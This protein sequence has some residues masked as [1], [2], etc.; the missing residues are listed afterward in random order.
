[1]LTIPHK[2][3]FKSGYVAI[4]GRPNVGKSTLLN[5]LLNLRLSSVTR[6]PQTTRHQIRGILN[7]TDHQIVFLDTPGI[8]APRY[9][10]QEAMLQAVH[11]A[12]YDADLILYMT[13]AGQESDTGV[14]KAFE[15]ISKLQKKVVIAINKIDL[16]GKAAVLPRIQACFDI[17]S[18][19]AIIPISA[20]KSDGLDVLRDTLLTAL[21]E[22]LPLYDQQQVTDQPERFFVAELIREQVFHYFADEIPYATNVIIDEFKERRNSKDFIR[23][24]IFVERD[25]QKGILIGKKGT[26]LQRIGKAARHDIEQLLDR[27]VFLQL[28]VKVKEKWRKRE[29][30][31]KD[32]GYYQ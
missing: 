16:Y 3:G 2:T 26:A 31:L 13:T 11:R 6:R 12:L 7:G 15:S 29:E 19:E 20:L 25:S 5:N 28:Q 10:L 1:V 4:V 18:P 21:P 30:I 27:P 14:A 24:I 22:G 17:Y 32:F 23:A 8:L 9:K